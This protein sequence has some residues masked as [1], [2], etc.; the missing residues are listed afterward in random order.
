ML[1][2]LQNSER[3]GKGEEEGKE[4]RKLGRKEKLEGYAHESNPSL[5]AKLV[6]NLFLL[7]RE[8][9]L[10]LLCINLTRV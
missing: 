9:I 4:G 8:I 1:N 7:Q 10:L 3:N 6:N 2:D 5:N